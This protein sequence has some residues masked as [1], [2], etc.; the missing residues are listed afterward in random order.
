MELVKSLVRLRIPTKTRRALIYG[1]PRLRHLEVI[2]EAVEFRHHF[3]CNLD[4]FQ[5]WCGLPLRILANDSMA[6]WHLAFLMAY[7]ICPKK[8]LTSSSP[9]MTL[10]SYDPSVKKCEKYMA[11]F[12]RGLGFV[13]YASGRSGITVANSKLLT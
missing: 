13:N 10:T 5:P 4:F 7:F 9:H 11:P 3:R 12:G 2:Q 1:S 6:H 8:I